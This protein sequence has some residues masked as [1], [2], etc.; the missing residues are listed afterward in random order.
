MRFSGT[1]VHF[2]TMCM[3]SSPVTMTSRSSR[4]PSK[5]RSSLSLV[6]FSESRNAP[7][8]SKSW[9]LIASS[10]SERIVSMFFSI[11]FTSGG[12]VIALM[13][14]R[15]PASSMTSI[16]LSGRKRPVI[17][18]S[19]SRTAA[20]NASSVSLAL[21]CASYFGRKPFKI[22]TASSTVGASTLTVWNRRSSAASFSMYFR[23]SL[24][25]VAP[26]HCSS[27]RLRAG[28]IMFEASMAPSAEPAPDDHVQLIDKENHILGATNLIHH[29]LDSLFELATIFCPGDHEREIEC[30]DAFIAQQFPH[31]ASR[32]FLSQPFDDGGLSNPCFTDQHWVVFGAP[33]ED[34][35]YAF[36][37]VLA[38]DDRVQ[39]ALFRQLGQI[40]AEHAQ[41][42]RIYI[43]LIALL[44]G[45]S[46]AFRR[47][48][49][50]VQFF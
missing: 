49:A 31:L 48:E 37:L 33:A 21:W 43:F 47:C 44:R 15:A 22:W 38:T 23:Y 17:Y 13:R 4:H 19:E 39:L 50:R 20:S 34:L 46:L 12:R 10:F 2:D 36:D 32:D 29:G 5:I 27:P 35:N 26:T 45:L 30:D 7:A 25:V 14:A 11:S 40:A 28:L 42:G 16:A 18:R 3:I 1:P 8:F 41:G 6:C 24:R 9:A